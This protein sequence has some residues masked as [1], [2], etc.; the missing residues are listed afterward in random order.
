MKAINCASSASEQIWMGINEEPLV[1]N[2]LAQINKQL[3]SKL[4]VH[5]FQRKTPVL[6][7]KPWNEAEAQIRCHFRKDK[8]SGKDL[9]TL[10]LG[11]RFEQLEEFLPASNGAPNRPTIVATIYSLQGRGYLDWEVQKEG[12]LPMLVDQIETFGFPFF[13]KYSK[14]DEAQSKFRMA[15]SKNSADGI[16]KL[17]ATMILQGKKKDAVILLDDAI[18][19]KAGSMPPIVAS[20]FR[21][22]KFRES[23]LTKL[24]STPEL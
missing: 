2:A 18:T 15:A 23:I 6:I 14:L 3:A 24:N 16:M 22:L 8:S 20:R 4:A 12:T 21:L 13:E 19:S 10:L 7:A 1:G 5:G 11:I 9:V 17:V